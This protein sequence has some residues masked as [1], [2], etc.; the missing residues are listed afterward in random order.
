MNLQCK[1]LVGVSKFVLSG[2]PWNV[3]SPLTLTDC[4]GSGAWCMARPL[5]D[6]PLKKKVEL[7]RSKLYSWASIGQFS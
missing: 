2:L 6:V 7:L 5:S 3:S 1:P 4:M